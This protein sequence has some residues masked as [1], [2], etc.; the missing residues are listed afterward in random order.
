MSKFSDSLSTVLPMFS[1]H[2]DARRVGWPPYNIKVGLVA[3]DLAFSRP[4]RL[5]NMLIHHVSGRIHQWHWG[6]ARGALA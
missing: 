1:Q 4:P 5:F 3:A 6:Y 2:L